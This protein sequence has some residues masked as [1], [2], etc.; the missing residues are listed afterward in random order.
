MYW[1]ALVIFLGYLVLFI[2]ARKEMAPVNTASVLK[3]FYKMALYLYKK[4]GNRLPRLFSSPQVERDLASLHPGE[5]RECLK[6]EYYG[7]KAAICLAVLFVGTLFGTAARFSAMDKVILGEDGTVLRGSYRDGAQ[8]ID[9]ETEYG[10]RQMD[11]RMEVQPRLL[12]EEEA[13]KLFDELTEK[14]PEYILGSNDSL[15]NVTSD[16]SL[17][18]KYGDFP[19]SVHWESSKPGLLGDSGQIFSLEEEEVV[20]KLSFRLTYGE[21]ERDGELSVTL[22][23]PAFTQEEQM[24]ME[25]E[26]ALRKSQDGSLSQEEWR[27]P[28]E[29]RGEGIRWRQVVE[30]NSLILWAV[31]LV[32]AAAVFLFLD[33]DLHEQLE[34]RKKILRREY[35][36]IVH[37]LA[38]FVGA[39]MTIR[40]AFQKIAGDY[41]EKRKEGGKRM[42]AYEEMLYTCRELRSGISESLAYEHLGKRTELQEYIRL[43]A[44]LSQNLK[45][46]NSTLLER[47]REEADK[48]AQER[49]QESRKMGEEAGTKLLVPMMLMLGVVMVIIMIPAFSNM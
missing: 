17:Q 4:L 28:A 34:K 13:G 22:R 26:E 47:L 41:E 6:T 37:K 9:I 35:P 39:G 8:K 1:I 33:R 18:E 20:V 45:R 36:Q 24:Y 2:L 49:L 32:T 16:L 11:F 15:Q 14:L 27:L 48:S 30:D 19:I 25:L 44:L 31:A 10:Q 7:K 46:G 3:P 29:W 23:P 38:L 21:Q 12:S 43:T 42:P 40:G 5:A